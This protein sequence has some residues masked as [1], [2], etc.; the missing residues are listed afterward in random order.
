[1]KSI[2]RNNIICMKIYDFM[3][4]QFKYQFNYIEYK[5]IAQ[6]EV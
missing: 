2:I 5:L 6:E 3:H 1:M 4:I